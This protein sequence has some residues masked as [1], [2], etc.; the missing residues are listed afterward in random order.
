MAQSL[1]STLAALVGFIFSLGFTY[2]ARQ[3]FSEVGFQDHASVRSLHT[4][5]TPKVGGLGLLPAL[6]I[7]L[8]AGHLVEGAI[9]DRQGFEGYRFVKLWAWL[10]PC[11]IVYV[12]CL[13][14]DRTKAEL[15]AA[16]RLSAFLVA[17]IIFVSLALHLTSR[18]ALTALTDS[19]PALSLLPPLAGALT[20]AGFTTLSLLAFTNF[21]NFMDGMDGL[22]GS[23][24]LIGF[25]ALAASAFQVSTGAT[26]GLAALVISASCLGFLFWN[27]PKARV[28]MGDTGSTFLGFSASALGWLGAVDGLWHW[29]F[30]FLVFYPFWFDA[31]FTLL[32][33]FFRGEKVWQAHREHFYQRAVLSLEGLEM[34]ARHLKV[35]VPSI[36]LMLVS[37]LIALTQHFQWLGPERHQP[38]IAFAVLLLI[39]SAGALWV[40][41]KYR[42]HLNKAAKDVKSPSV[43]GFG[44]P[45]NHH[46]EP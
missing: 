42:T 8:L 2:W 23:M 33:R 37:S 12:V 36:G 21:F 13:L 39:H 11:F 15:P 4:G 5:S 16:T 18:G 28:F 31:T 40:D 9:A 46:S 43:G 35:L 25:A 30:P 6:C 22:A 32:R 19:L 26:V 24:G 27:W 44:R 41:L 45:T 14:S 17:C 20:A 29:S 34:R 3:R 7:G 10:G 1:S 38:W